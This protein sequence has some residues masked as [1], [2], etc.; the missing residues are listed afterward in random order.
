MFITCEN[1]NRY[2]INDI[3]NVNE[4][5]VIIHVSCELFQPFDLHETLQQNVG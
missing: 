5:I 1:S 2:I 3:N 4:V